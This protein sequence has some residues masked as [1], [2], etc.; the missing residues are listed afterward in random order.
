MEAIC[1]PDPEVFRTLGSGS[2]IIWT[3]PDPSTTS[4]K[5]NKIDFLQ[6]CDIYL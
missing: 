6:F 1:V 3:D 5:L 2:V 4:K